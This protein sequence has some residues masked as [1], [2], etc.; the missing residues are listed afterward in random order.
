[1]RVW[2]FCYEQGITHLI[3]FYM[4]DRENP[5]VTSTVKSVLQYAVA[6]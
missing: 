4:F 1:M 5:E 2:D 6:E 3:S